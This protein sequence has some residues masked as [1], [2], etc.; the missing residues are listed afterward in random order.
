ML[1][2]TLTSQWHVPHDHGRHGSCSTCHA[3][4][5]H[6]H[7]CTG[8]EESSK[9]GQQATSAQTSYKARCLLNQLQSSSTVTKPTHAC[10]HDE[11]RTT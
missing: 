6:Q 3:H 5:G 10:K 8:G 1:K 2:R 9:A 7:T 11:A 4:L